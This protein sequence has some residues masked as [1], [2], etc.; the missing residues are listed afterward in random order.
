[1]DE[2]FVQYMAA[3][4]EYNPRWDKVS[5]WPTGQPIPDLLVEGLIN[6]SNQLTRSHCSLK[7]R[8]CCINA[9]NYIAD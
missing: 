4:T 8:T 7:T 5:G 1:M 6:D 3:C 9:F 2:K